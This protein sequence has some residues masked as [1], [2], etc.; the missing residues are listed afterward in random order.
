[1]ANYKIVKYCGMCK[2]RFVVQKGES[3]RIYCDDCQKRLEEQIRKEQKEES[4]KS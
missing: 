2:K 3:K 1:M 4:E